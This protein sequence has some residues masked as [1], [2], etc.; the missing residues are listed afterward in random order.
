MLGLYSLCIQYVLYVYGFGIYY[1]KYRHVYYSHKLIYVVYALYLTNIC[2]CY[3]GK[4][5]DIEF[6][7]LGLRGVSIIFSSGDDGVGSQIMRTDKAK[8]CSQTWPGWPASS[9]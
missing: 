9:P 7:K 5:C 3:I 1:Y 2:T 6:M 4:R 8:G